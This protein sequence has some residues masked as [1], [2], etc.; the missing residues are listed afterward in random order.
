[1]KYEDQSTTASMKPIHRKSFCKGQA[2]QLIEK[3]VFCSFFSIYDLE[4]C[5]IYE[6]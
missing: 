2:C 4:I 5:F 1:M 3:Y 6:L